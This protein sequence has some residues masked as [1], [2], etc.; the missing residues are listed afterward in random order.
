MGSDSYY[1]EIFLKL[2]Y[3]TDKL[4]FEDCAI[5][6]YRSVYPALAA[7][8]GG[9]D[10]GRD[11]L[12]PS[13]EGEQNFAIVTT[14][15]DVKANLV[16]SLKS[17]QKK[18]GGKGEVI[19]ITNQALT[20][21]KIDELKAEAKALGYTL[22]N[23]HQRKDFANRLV[24]NPK[25]AY[26]LLGVTGD[27]P[28]LSKIP[29]GN[30]LPSAKIIGRTEQQEWLLA[31]NG[32]FVLSGQP[33]SGKT[34]L[35][36]E[37]AEKK[38][39]YFVKSDNLTQVANDVRQK[40]PG[41]LILDDAHS[42]TELL[43]SL[44]NLRE[45]LSSNFS[46][47]AS[48][49]PEIKD[50]VIGPLNI[51]GSKV[52]IIQ[53]LD[54]DQ[55]VEVIKAA[56][57]D[58]P[59]RL[60]Q[61]IV[62]QAEGRPGLAV[63]LVHSVK[64]GGIKDLQTANSLLTNLRLWLGK[65]IALERVLASF[66]MGGKYGMKIEDVSRILSL[67]RVDIDEL[68][69]RAAG[70]GILRQNS[71]GIIS[72]GPAALR[73]ALIRDRFLNS[74]VI[75]PISPYLDASP[76][77]EESI[78]EV[79]LAKHRGALVKDQFLREL[80]ASSE[81]QMTWQLYAG[82]GP[83]EATWVVK[84]HPERILECSL[85]CLHYIPRETLRFLMHASIGDT[86]NLHSHP[87][88]PLRRITDWVISGD[89][90]NG[91]D[92]TRRESLF[93]TSIQWLKSEEDPEIGITSLCLSLTPE[94]ET[95][96]VAPGSG[97]TV[98]FTTG[99]V[100]LECIGFVEKAWNEAA[101]FLCSYL[102]Q[103]PLL[104][105]NLLNKW[106]LLTPSEVELSVTHKE[107]ML[108]M[109]KRIIESLEEC[110]QSNLAIRMELS[111][112]K[113]GLGIPQK[114]EDFG[115]QELLYSGPPEGK[116]SEQWQTEKQETILKRIDDWRL[117]PPQDVLAD[118]SKAEL[119]AAAIGSHGFFGPFA[120]NN[121]AEK[122]ADPV[123]W[124]KEALK[125][126]WKDSDIIRRLATRIAVEDPIYW[127]K[128]AV[129]NFDSPDFANLVVSISLASNDSSKDLLSLAYKKLTGAGYLIDSHGFVKYPES[130]MKELLKHED[131][132]VRL[133]AAL[134]EWHATD[135]K[136][137]EEVRQLWE[138]AIASSKRTDYALEDVF[139]KKPALAFEWLVSILRDPEAHHY[140]FERLV[141][142]TV[143][144]LSKEQRIDLL[145]QLPISFST[146]DY[147]R[148]LVN[149][150]PDVYVHVFG[151]RSLEDYL[152]AP[153]EREPSSN[154]EDLAK[155][156]IENGVSTERIAAAILYPEEAYSGNRSDMLNSR[157]QKFLSLEQ[158]QDRGIQEIGRI[159]KKWANEQKEKALEQEQNERIYGLDGPD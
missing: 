33:G 132:D 75:E 154:W 31:Q 124:F 25:L 6:L 158:N 38:N 142:V 28:A 106:A 116:W 61:E 37:L 103:Y 39:A 12:L 153:L 129:E 64:K 102:E 84:K 47:G 138:A 118:L 5:D 42:K 13:A 43:K 98:I 86:R 17:N 79:I 69:T 60:I 16:K 105:L 9:G 49:W 56:G 96:S 136:P 92:L 55:M 41:I 14:Q 76:N 148:S 73:H 93:Q 74:F 62:K 127:N 131:P 91:W 121:L 147:V 99:F 125:H 35:L 21:S 94:F 89:P 46:V 10:S 27:P 110:S 70:T 78:R 65:D 145:D 77:R 52:S 30:L 40:K 123:K 80:V 157:I 50:A 101:A 83:E 117:K 139:A 8:P 22:K 18:M 100:S 155:V 82:L 68:L 143:R 11:G 146:R 135:E 90:R 156:A 32:D 24:D 137:R 4:L 1:D 97:L 134:N 71:S 15:T 107:R 150:D 128:W 58:G 87:E 111:G 29:A 2:S 48:C 126:P 67:R 54:A 23:I 20:P 7:F 140:R 119:E 133:N 72:I 149:D 114:A 120:M 95:N 63:T 159:A 81:E 51:P 122:I 85:E 26:K 3:V 34:A 115:L 130:T 44:L 108:S 112:I 109:A 88:K 144:A 53:P 151:I 66:A 104:I 113:T 59:G 141:A 57:L 19:L 45:E 152:E 36:K